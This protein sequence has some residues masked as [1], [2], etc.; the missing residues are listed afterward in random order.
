MNFYNPYE[1]FSYT[2]PNLVSLAQLLAIALDWLVKQVLTL[3]VVFV[4]TENVMVEPFSNLL[5]IKMVKVNDI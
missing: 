1:T 2:S 5:V 4:A 3:R